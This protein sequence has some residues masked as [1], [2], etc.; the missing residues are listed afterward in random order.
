VGWWSCRFVPTTPDGAT[1][2]AFAGLLQR[3]GARV[4][5]V[6]SF[7]LRRY[8]GVEGFTRAQGQ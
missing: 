5:W 1:D 8:G 4:P 7:K 3:V 6:Q 2:A